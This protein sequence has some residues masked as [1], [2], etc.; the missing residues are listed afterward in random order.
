MQSHVITKYH[1]I[2]RRVTTLGYNIVVGPDVSRRNRSISGTG[3]SG[4]R[5]ARLGRSNPRCTSRSKV[6]TLTPKAVAAS[7]R[8][9]ASRATS[10]CF[11]SLSR[12][13]DGACLLWLLFIGSLKP[14]VIVRCLVFCRCSRSRSPAAGALQPCPGPMCGRRTGRCFP[15]VVLCRW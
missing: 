13:P 10:G 8:L 12:S 9:S 14:K 15:A 1:K 7:F 2:G 11:V 4:R 5:S 3:N 6:G